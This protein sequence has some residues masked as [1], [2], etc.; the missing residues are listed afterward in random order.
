[1]SLV[2]A[3]DQGTSSSRFLVSEWLFIC[4]LCVVCVCVCVCL[5]VCAL[6]FTIKVFA[7]WT[8]G[9]IKCISYTIPLV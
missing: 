6:L 5:C 7:D 9:H 4:M 8:K 3:I 2:G 1:M